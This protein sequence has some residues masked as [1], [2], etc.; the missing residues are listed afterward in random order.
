MR[1]EDPVETG[2]LHGVALLNIS[3]GRH[4]L[5]LND[6]VVACGG[7]RAADAGAGQQ[8]RELKRRVREEGDFGLVGSDAGDLSENTVFIKHRHAGLELILASQIDIQVMRE[9]VSGF[10]L[11]HAD[12]RTDVNRAADTGH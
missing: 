5:Q 1:R 8:H 6:M 12:K 3:R 11:D 4:I 9:G 7:R 2:G 10:P